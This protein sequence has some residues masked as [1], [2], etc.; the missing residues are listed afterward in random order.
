MS[1]RGPVR[2]TPGTA[3]AVAVAVVAA[4]IAFQAVFWASDT[5]PT[6]RAAS[7]PPASTAVT[8]A[9]EP[10]T[11]IDR[12]PTD[13]KVVCLTF[14]AGADTGHTRAI[15]DILAGN[16]VKA[17][18]FL[19]EAWLRGNADLGAAI[20]RDGHALGNH[21]A[22]HPHLPTL[23]DEEIVR[24]FRV[25]EELARTTLGRS[26]TPFFRPPF[27][28]YDDRVRRLAAT[29]GYRYVVLWT[30][31][32]LDWK[33]LTADELVDRVLTRVGPGSIVLMHVGSQTNQPEALP[34]I[35]SGLRERGYRFATLEEA[36]DQ[37]EPPPPGPGTRYTVVRG[38]TLS[39]IARRF[40]VSVQDI[41]RANRL[42]SPDEL[43][44]G[45]VLLIP[46]SSADPG[47]N[48]GDGGVD[49]G[50]H[51]S[52][53]QQPKPATPWQRISAVLSRCWARLMSFL[54]RLF[55]R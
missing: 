49:Q 37:A 17:T 43:G 12:V 6:A 15:L 30:V 31:D 19:T 36:L 1:R 25:T 10:A 51:G 40:G 14:D 26:L 22:T 11:V 38:D 8:P 39:S 45:M 34:R 5:V 47:C 3:L 28:E 55:G 27:G 20:V 46:A 29:E 9:D 21:T 54:G 24:E 52:D 42:A 23:S 2:G 18:F 53:D 35:I 16:G 50:G 13:E 41:I 33:Q 48:P 4:V 32:S 7:D 44:V